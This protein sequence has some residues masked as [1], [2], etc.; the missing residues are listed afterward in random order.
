MI[1]LIKLFFY[2]NGEKIIIRERKK[3]ITEK[4]TRYY[5]FNL[6]K[7]KYISSLYFVKYN[8]ELKETI[9]KFDYQK[10]IYFIMIDELGVIKIKKVEE[11]VV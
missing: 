6:T 9:Y 1:N 10:E 5:L 8:K 3:N 11:I 2:W 4:R 7:K